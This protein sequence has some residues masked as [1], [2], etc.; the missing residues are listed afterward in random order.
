MVN[1]AGPQYQ[2]DLQR[3]LAECQ[4]IAD[5]AAQP[6]RDLRARAARASLD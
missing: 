5:V 6:I 3:T 2:V 1:G 4:P